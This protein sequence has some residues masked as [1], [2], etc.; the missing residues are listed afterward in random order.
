[1]QALYQRYADAYA[2]G[3]NFVNL[4]LVSALGQ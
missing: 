4:A 1:V 3:Q 2:T